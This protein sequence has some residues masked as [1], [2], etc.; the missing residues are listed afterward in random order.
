MTL[1]EKKKGARSKLIARRRRRLECASV[2]EEK[3]TARCTQPSA[4]FNR[5]VFSPYFFPSPCASLRGCPDRAAAASL[6]RA[7]DRASRDATRRDA[8]PHARGTRRPEEN[9]YRASSRVLGRTARRTHA[10]S[11]SHSPSSLCHAACRSLP[12]PRPPPPPPGLLPSRSCA[13]AAREYA[14]EDF[15]IRSPRSFTVHSQS[16]TSTPPPIS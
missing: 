5:H 8:L 1:R 6:S 2:E 10:L 12:L 9:R 7:Y 3:K 13:H 15:F 14:R 11:L 16:V 4:L